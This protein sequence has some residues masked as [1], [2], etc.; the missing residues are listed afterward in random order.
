MDEK[1][2]VIKEIEVSYDIVLVCETIEKHVF[3]STREDVI[4]LQNL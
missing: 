2:D 4:F 1:I 3:V